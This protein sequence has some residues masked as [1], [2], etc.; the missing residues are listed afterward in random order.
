[1]H[2]NTIALGVP[3]LMI[4]V[5]SM[6]SNGPVPSLAIR[7]RESHEKDCEERL[8]NIVMK[9][10]ADETELSIL[11]DEIIES[12]QKSSRVT[13]VEVLRL[14]GTKTDPFYYKYEHATNSYSLAAKLNARLGSEHGI[15][16]QEIHVAHKKRCIHSFCDCGG[17]DC[18]ISCMCWNL[19]FGCVPL[20]YWIPR[21]CDYMVIGDWCITA[22]AIA[23]A[24]NTP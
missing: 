11:Y 21:I 4:P 9:Q 16:I 2:R 18:G 13:A 3:A 12:L 5:R 23:I 19:F 17:S 8:A 20:V 7:V 10:H 24:V 22:T 1:M 14:G 15:I 6:D